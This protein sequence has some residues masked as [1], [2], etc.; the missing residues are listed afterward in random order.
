MSRTTIDRAALKAAALANLSRLRKDYV[1]AVSAFASLAAIAILVQAIGTALSRMAYPFTLEWMEGATMDHI[2]VVLAGRPIYGAP[3]FEWTPAI[4]PPLYYWVCAAFMKVFGV[5]LYWARFVSTCSF[6]GS[7][8]LIARFVWKEVGGVVGPLAA[9][10][11]FAISFPVT[12]AWVDLARVD[13]LFFFLFLAGAYLARHGTSRRSAI[14]AGVFLF[15]SFFAKQT[16]LVLAVPI[17]GGAILVSWRRGLIAA[18]VFAGLTIGAVQWMDLVSEGWFRYYVFEVPRKHSLP[19]RSEWH[20]FVLVSTWEVMPAAVAMAFA[21]IVGTMKSWRVAALY[22]GA[23][24]VTGIAGF[25]S[26]IKNGGFVNAMI[27]YCGVVAILSGIA[28]AWSLRQATASPVGRRAQVAVLAVLLLQFLQLTYD[29]RRF[30]P[31]RRDLVAGNAMIE[32]W[33]AL[34]VQGEVYSFGFGYY[35]YL[36]GGGEIHASSMAMADVLRT[37]DQVR[38]QRLIHEFEAAMASRRFRAIV[39]DESFKLV[40]PEYEAAVKRNY[41]QDQ[42][43]FLPDEG[44]RTWPRTGFGARPNQVWVR[45]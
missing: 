26:L 34:R 22:G 14:A 25:S 35:D 43:L 10:A 4:Y 28:V 23:W 37:D 18:A 29:Q 31:R 42:T 44:D 36:A 9:A 39:W 1:F 24:I 17:L 12:G 30:V 8:I 20:H 13:S 3:S 21:A 45:R 41:V 11:L 15:L 27:P 7:L 40:N 19:P 2:R 33:K 38:G 6:V 5:S 32:R 16:G